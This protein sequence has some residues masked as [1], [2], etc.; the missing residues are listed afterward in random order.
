MAQWVWRGLQ[1]VVERA[2][3][4]RDLHKICTIPGVWTGN[5][6]IRPILCK[7][8]NIEPSSVGRHRLVSAGWDQSWALIRQSVPSSTPEV[9]MDLCYGLFV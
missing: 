3:L 1:R 8:C 5:S 9:A 4:S 7:L 2:D 6:E